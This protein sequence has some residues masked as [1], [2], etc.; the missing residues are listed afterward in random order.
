MLGQY[1]RRDQPHC[2]QNAERHDD[3]VVEITED[4]HEIRD[5][6]DGGKSVGSYEGRDCLGMPR[7][8]RVARREIERVQVTP[9][10]SGPMLQ[11]AENAQEGSVR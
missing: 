6:V 2:Q 8:S 9:R 7:H 1:V 5:Q 4:R 10:E 11:A 3:Q